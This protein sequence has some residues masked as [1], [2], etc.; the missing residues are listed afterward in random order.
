MPVTINLQNIT[1]PNAVIA[2]SGILLLGATYCF[3]GYQFFRICLVANA[4]ALGIWCGTVAAWLIQQP[5]NGIAYLA[6]SL[7]LSLIFTAIAWFFYRA[8]CAI[9]SIPVAAA[10]ILVAGTLLGWFDSRT[11]EICIQRLDPNITESV[12]LPA[13]PLAISAI[14]GLL[15]GILTF[16]TIR[17]S[18]ILISALLGATMA[19]LAAAA[20]VSEGLIPLFDITLGEN[21]ATWARLTI[22]L[23]TGALAA[24]GITAQTAMI[25]L[26]N[27]AFAPDVPKITPT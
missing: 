15:Y 5:P 17:I 19:I 10:I 27:K 20:I 11:I 3:F 13:W 16:C 18:V 2:L 1:S 12:N 6:C 4:A 25:D 22:I 9:L 24:A 23:S 7:S 8:V 26:F 14:G 21:A